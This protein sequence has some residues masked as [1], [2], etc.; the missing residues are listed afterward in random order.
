MLNSLLPSWTSFIE[1][2]ALV[3][4]PFGIAT[5]FINLCLT[6][7]S[8]AVIRITEKRTLNLKIFPFP[9]SGKS[10]FVI[11]A[12]LT[13]TF[14]FPLSLFLLYFSFLNLSIQKKTEE[15]S[16][17][18]RIFNGLKIISIILIPIIAMFVILREGAPLAIVYSL[19]CFLVG[20]FF[21]FAFTSKSSELLKKQ[22]E[23]HKKLVISSLIII[24][25]LSS[26]IFFIRFS[27][28]TPKSVAGITNSSLSVPLKIMTYNIRLPTIEQNPL[29][30]W[31]NRKPYFVDYVNSF[32]LDIIGVQEAHYR[33]VV[34][35]TSNLQPGV[36]RYYGVGRDDG[37]FGGEYSAIIFRTDKFRLI[38][39]GT[40]WLSS[41]PASPSRT[42]GNLHFRI[43]TWVRLEHK[44]TRKQFFVFNTHFDFSNE[45]QTNAAK[46]I[47]EFIS[48]Y[49]GNL[50]V[51][52]M[53][54]FNLNHTTESYQ[55]LDNYGAK[56]L[57]DSYR[58]IHGSPIPFDYSVSRFDANYA[59]NYDRRIDFIFVSESVQ[60]INISIPKDSYGQNLTYS[61][62][63][64]V[65]LHCAL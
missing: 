22:I 65:I 29:N 34:Y 1:I 39:G 62:H 60:P 63:Y 24:T 36:Y 49:T 41:Q 15:P 10:L 2:I 46:Q 57:Q 14:T 64:P 30:N 20:G 4:F 16:K 7:T 12:M 26:S 3:L 53:G 59:P 42:W 44:E 52:L 18:T 27:L 35:I 6:L 13:T 25:L 17:K 51:F 58:L 21:Y 33:Q 61:D 8:L 32:S 23:A 56:P 48:E 40:F 28:Y 37:A 9:D 31:D 11:L 47:Q 45:F 43:C 38:D 54:D 55:Y 19:I 5:I 50:P